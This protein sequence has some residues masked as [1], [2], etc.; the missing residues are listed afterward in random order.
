MSGVEI[1]NF[2]KRNI[3]IIIKRLEES[4]VLVVPAA[5]DHLFIPELEVDDKGVSLDVNGFIH[6]VKVHPGYS[7][8]KMNL[9]RPV[10]DNE[11]TVVH[12]GVV[13]V[14]SRTAGRIYLKAPMGQLSKVTVEV[15]RIG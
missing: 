9:D 1:L 7:P 11:Y 13:K 4:G 12:P 15:L 3:G 10:V 6:Y 2:L 14:I 8:V 5:R